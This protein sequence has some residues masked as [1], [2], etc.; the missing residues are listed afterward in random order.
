MAHRLTVVNGVKRKSLVSQ[1]R[2]ISSYFQPSE[3]EYVNEAVYPPILDLSYEATKDRKIENEAQKITNLP[4]V[5]EKLIELNAPKYYGWWACQLKEKVV[6]YDP[7]P[8]CQYA[9][10]TCLSNGLPPVYS[11]LEEIASNSVP[12]IKEKL[13]EL[14]LQEFEYVEKR[15]TIHA[16][17]QY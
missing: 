9:T 14:L 11:E 1:C 10:R 12:K 16:V 17:I 15:Y 7:L 5:E 3:S 13:N 4:T 6:P 2:R 8:F